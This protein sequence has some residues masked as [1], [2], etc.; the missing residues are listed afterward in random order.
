MR[1]WNS[2]EERSPAPSSSMAVTKLARPS[3]PS[4]SCELPPSKAKRM[5]IIGTECSSTSQASMPPGLLM[6]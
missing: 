6:V 3:L 5:A 1:S 2:R 4:G